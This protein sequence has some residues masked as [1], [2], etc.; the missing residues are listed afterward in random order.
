M[1]YIYLGFN[2]IIQKDLI[3]NIILKYFKNFSAYK[4][5]GFY[6]G[7]KIKAIKIDIY[8]E[9]W[10]SIYLLYKEL[11]DKLNQ[12]EILIIHN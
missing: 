11:K 7:Y 8:T 12:K 3:Y 2:D 1:Y 10:K 9:D 6:N 4:V 5:D